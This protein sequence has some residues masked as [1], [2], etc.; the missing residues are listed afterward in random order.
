MLLD[1]EEYVIVIEID[2][3]QQTDYDI[4]CKN[5]R[6]MKISRDNNHRNW[7]FIRFNPDDY[8]DKKNKLLRH[9]QTI[10]GNNLTKHILENST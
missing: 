7:V 2:E 9:A 4:S 3:N 8:F 1:L 6:L 5:T 10:R